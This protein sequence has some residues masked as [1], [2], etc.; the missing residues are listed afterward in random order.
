[1]KRI[2]YFTGYR[3]VAQEWSGSKL[4]SSVYFEPDEQGLD[5]FSAYLTSLKNEPIRLLV[6]LIEEEFRQEKIPLLRGSDRGK[7]IDRF[8]EKYF[9]NSRFRVA[10]QIE[11]IKKDRKEERLLLAGLTNPDLLK[12]WL[13][14]IRNTKTPLVGIQSLPIVSES[15]INSL[16]SDHNCIIMVSQQ[17]PS[18]LR[19]SVFINGKLILSRLV[20]IA[21]FY[22]GDY[23]SDVTRDV[24]STQRYLVSQ[25]IIDRSETIAV[26]ILSNDRHL[27]KLKIKCEKDNYF[28]YKIHKIKDLIDEHKIE[29]DEDPD[30]SSA[31][32]CYLATKKRY[33]NHYATNKEKKYLY[34]YWGSLG[35]KIAGITSIAIGIG[36]IL[37]SVA[38]GFIYDE[39]IK[40]MTLLEQKYNSKFNQ[41]NEQMIDSSVSTINMKNVVL[42]IEQLE[43]KYIRS[44]YEL[45]ALVSE[46]IA[47]FPDMRISS[48]NWYV[49]SSPTATTADSQAKN[50]SSNRR[51]ARNTRSRANQ[52]YEILTVRGELIDFNGDYR[53]ALSVIDDIEDTM[54]VSKKYDDVIITQRP[55]NI[56]SN[57]KLSGDVSQKVNISR[58]GRRAQFAFKVVKEVNL[59]EK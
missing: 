16:E 28:D 45:M 12:P 19:Q 18:N 37:T 47:L 46:D 24:E 49:A 40:E 44:P 33:T 15:L 3:M 9:R 51:R 53:Y 42:T 56:E 59:N 57:E 17:V 26:H 2:L 34:H 1:M 14:I 50:V 48:L 32:F 39:S 36:F 54:K 25:R 8:Y 5:L 11:V 58:S 22:Q 30:F 55:L 52:L 10:K 4:K 35:L 7:M 41:L 20:P 6:D 27:D 43:K 38:K 13:E 23:A 31:I 21:S 29:V